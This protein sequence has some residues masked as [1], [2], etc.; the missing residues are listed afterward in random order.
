MILEASIFCLAINIYHEAR[1]EPLAGQL[2]VGFSTMNR[3]ADPRYPD[4]ICGVVYDAKYNELSKH[5]IKH[6]CQYSW[7]CDGKSDQPTEE[8]ALS[9]ATTLAKHII[10]GSAGLDFTE[11]STHYH[12][13]YVSPDWSSPKYMTKI[14]TIGNHIFYR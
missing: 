4:T 10:E 3:V 5:P 12:A 2:A 14:L 6:R 7:F 9:R 13:S 1:S 8:K 11:G